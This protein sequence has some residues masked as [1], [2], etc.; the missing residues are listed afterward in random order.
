M[1]FGGE[2]MKQENMCIVS[3]QEVAHKIFEMKLKGKLVDMMN[4]S[5][6]F[7][8]IK[9]NRQD[10]ILRRPISIA[11]I[12]E[13]TVTILYRVVGLGTQNFSELKSGDT[14]D[15]L[16]PLGHGFEI[17]HIR[18][19]D[20]V[21][22]VGGGI[23][24]APLYEL[25][26]QLYEKHANIT[27]VLGFANKDDCYYLEKFEQL[28]HVVITTDDGSYGIKGH[29]GN[30]IGRVNPSSVYA[31]GPIPLLNYVQHKF[32]KIEH[33]YLSM[34]ERMACGMGACHACDTKDKKKRVCYDGPVF[35]AKEVEL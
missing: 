21:L 16:G 26:K 15:V 12:D 20:E 34:E 10:L 30:G 4:E 19:N 27:F 14:V 1:E 32:E 33:V 35:N 9:T 31:C 25:G 17:S 5:G 28:G 13:E 22:V 29:V 23:G 2:T 3:N 11:S 6:Q 7:L 24:V 18:E 8:H